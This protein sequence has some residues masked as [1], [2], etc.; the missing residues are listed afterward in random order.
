MSTASTAKSGDLRSSKRVAPLDANRLPGAAA[1][2]NV[3]ER[4]T[5]A[6]DPSTSAASGSS[7]QTASFSS[8]SSASVLRRKNTHAIES[9]HKIL[10]ST[11]DARSPVQPTD[12]QLLTNSILSNAERQSVIL[13]YQEKLIDSCPTLNELKKALLYLS[14]SS[15][16]QILEERHLVHKC[17]YPP[18]SN[19]SP[20]HA[21]GSFVSAA[22][23]VGKFRINL[24]SQKVTATDELD[25]G[26]AGHSFQELKHLYC[27]KPCY[28]RSEWVLRWILTDKEIGF[29]A[30]PS[31]G[32]EPLVDGAG[33]VEQLT[34]LSGDQALELLEDI[35][36]QQ[37]LDLFNTDAAT[38]EI[39]EAPEEEYRAPTEGVRPIEALSKIDK[40]KDTSKMLDKLPVIERIV[41]PSASLTNTA[42]PPRVLASQTSEDIPQTASAVTSASTRLTAVPAPTSFDVDVP[43]H[44]GRKFTPA[45]THPTTTSFTTLNGTQH[46]DNE[47]DD[48]DLREMELNK[49]LR[50]ASLASGSR[51]RR[52]NTSISISTGA[53]STATEPDQN[54]SRP[55]QIGETSDDDEAWE[56]DL[57]P[58]QAADQRELRRIMD[59]ALG[60]RDQQRQLGLLD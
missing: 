1:S 43:N 40:A 44:V 5:A 15:W 47:D 19:P 31:T 23:K 53:S 3:L 39:E 46:L 29:A 16:G 58:Q 35:E 45:P 17:A 32:A 30:A 4:N 11:T 12:I 60:V 21:N 37:G 9:V 41:P 27:S 33:S 54:P 22:R 59:L 10:A 52:K 42:P 6:T 2:L 18:C 55:D 36:A 56:Q 8:H 49:I 48:V 57:T 50:F 51:P 26:E 13:Q 28:A 7:S 34:D 24:G 20:L 38:F 14:T 25:L